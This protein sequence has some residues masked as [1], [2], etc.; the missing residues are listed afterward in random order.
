MCIYFPTEK[1][2]AIGASEPFGVQVLMNAHLAY[3]NLC[4]YLMPH[5]IIDLFN[6]PEIG[7]RYSVNGNR[8]VAKCLI[9]EVKSG[10]DEL[11]LR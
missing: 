3:P 1:D 5:A 6:A 7:E 4:A 8:A 10:M 9:E 11:T 2:L